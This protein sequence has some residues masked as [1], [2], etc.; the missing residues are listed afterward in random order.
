MY[1]GHLMIVYAYPKASLSVE[2]IDFAR[3]HIGLENLRVMNRR[4]V[5]RARNGSIKEVVLPAHGKYHSFVFADADI[6]P[7]WESKAFLDLETDVAGCRHKQMNPNCWDREDTFHCPLFR[8][9]RQ[10]FETVK[11]PWFFH[12]FNEDGT[13]ITMCECNYFRRKVL[14]AGFTISHCGWANHDCEGSWH[15]SESVD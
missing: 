1:D 2:L 14:D 15:G 13:E 4:H 10:V 9:R 12:Q 11:P 8:V 5:I 7:T 3:R 6:R